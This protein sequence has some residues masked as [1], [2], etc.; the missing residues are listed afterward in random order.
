MALEL[1]EEKISLGENGFVGPGLL[2]VIDVAVVVGV[3]SSCYL[4]LNC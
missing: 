4:D 2:V 1:G 3:V